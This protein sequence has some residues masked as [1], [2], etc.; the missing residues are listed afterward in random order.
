MLH[1]RAETL[2]EKINFAKPPNA[3]KKKIKFV[4]SIKYF[5]QKGK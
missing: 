2:Q 4:S 3:E 5:F 1:V